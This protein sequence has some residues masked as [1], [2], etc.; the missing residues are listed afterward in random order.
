[1]EADIDAVRVRSLA[2]YEDVLSSGRT[3]TPTFLKQAKAEYA[4]L[5]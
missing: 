2:A 3:P 5:K 1:L 4:T